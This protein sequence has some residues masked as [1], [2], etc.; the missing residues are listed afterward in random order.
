MPIYF[1]K[2]TAPRAQ[3]IAQRQLSVPTL[4]QRCA[5]PIF[6]LVRIDRGGFFRCGGLV[7]ETRLELVTRRLTARTSASAVWKLIIPRR[8]RAFS[9]NLISRV[10]FVAVVSSK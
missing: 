4:D 10:D 9:E 7:G 1:G 2:D 8:A 3:F 5:W 6:S